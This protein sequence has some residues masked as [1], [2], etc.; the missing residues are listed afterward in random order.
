M[1]A[2]RFFGHRL[3][4]ITICFEGRALLDR[5]LSWRLPVD[6]SSLSRTTDNITW[7]SICK[8]LKL[9]VDT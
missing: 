5:C 3:A 4:N 7:A 8:G 1:Q 2:P 6:L 9:L